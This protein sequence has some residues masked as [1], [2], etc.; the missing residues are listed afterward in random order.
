MVDNMRSVAE[1]GARQRLQRKVC[2]VYDI[3]V[4]SSA[5]GDMRVEL[6]GE[7]DLASAAELRSTLDN[8][9]SFRRPTTVDLSS[10]TFLDLQSTRELAVRSQLYGH[11]LTLVNPSWQARASVRA[12]KLE[13]WTRFDEPA[14]S[15]RPLKRVS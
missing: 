15:S 9:A 3:Q 4:R 11:H 5:G 10:V 7:F 2:S 6:R 1:P 14:T 8:V 12:C 13:S